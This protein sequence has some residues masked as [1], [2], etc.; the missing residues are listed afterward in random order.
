L[1]HGEIVPLRLM[2]GFGRALVPVVAAHGQ[3]VPSAAPGVNS[4]TASH[5][6]QEV[7]VSAI[8]RNA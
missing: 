2:L 7:T 6:L 8:C 3:A 4:A 5:Q 1:R